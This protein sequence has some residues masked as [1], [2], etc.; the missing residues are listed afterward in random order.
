MHCTSHSVLTNSLMLLS[1]IPLMHPSRASC[2]CAKVLKNTCFW[3]TQWEL[4]NKHITHLINT[5]LHAVATTLW[6][7]QLISLVCSCY[8]C[9]HERSS[10]SSFLQLMNTCN[11]GACR[12]Q[13]RFCCRTVESWSQNAGH[14]AEHSPVTTS[15]GAYPVLQMLGSFDKH[16][17]K[18][19]VV[20]HM[21]AM[22]SGHHHTCRGCDHIFQLPRVFA[23]LQHHLS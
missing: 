20:G 22:G 21:G 17:G 14:S 5:R 9:I 19:A 7:G 11:S 10:N 1:L 18:S 12:T 15:A 8:N 3:C 13:A 23:C 2:A 6:L 4:L 16:D